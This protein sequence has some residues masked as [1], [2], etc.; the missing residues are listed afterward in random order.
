VSAL[1]V[2]F[3]IAVIGPIRRTCSTAK[4]ILKNGF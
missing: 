1:A 3:H 4:D 2:P